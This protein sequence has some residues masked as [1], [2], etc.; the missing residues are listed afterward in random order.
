MTYYVG[1]T[2][3]SVLDGISKRYFYGL[4]RND[5]GELFLAVLDQL[6]GGDENIVLIN[7]QGTADEN[8]PDYEE[9]IDFL[10][11]INQDHSIEYEN[12]RYPQF[13]WDGRS[14]LYYVEDETGLLVQRISE[15]FDYP[16]GISTN[17]YSDGNEDTV[18]ENNEYTT[19]VNGTTEV[20][21][22]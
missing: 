22:S 18:L 21:K 20:A 4:R 1:N 6:A 9:G 8:Y 13:R 5:D 3:Q 15:S 2:P 17:G 12:L 16:A 7:E 10:D 19:T 11:G 14:L